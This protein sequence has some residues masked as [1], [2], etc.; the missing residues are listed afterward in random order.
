M[1]KQTTS[2][3]LATYQRRYRKLRATSESVKMTSDLWDTWEKEGMKRPKIDQV[4]SG[5]SERE[6]RFFKELV[7]QCARFAEK[8]EGV[9][10]QCALELYDYN[11]RKLSA[12]DGCIILTD[13]AFER[14][15]FVLSL[16]CL[17]IV[18]ET[19]PKSELKELKHWLRTV[20]Q[21]WFLGLKEFPIPTGG[22]ERFLAGDYETSEMGVFL[23]N[24]MY[25]FCL[26]H[27]IGHHALG[28][29]SSET[30]FML[31]SERITHNIEVDAQSHEEE[32][33]ADDYAIRVYSNLHLIKDGRNPLCFVWWYEFA[34]LLLMDIF[35]L[36][37]EAR[38][39]NGNSHSHP[40]P[41]ERKE[42]LLS[43]GDL[44]RSAPLYLDLREAVST[45]I[46]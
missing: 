17:H 14:M 18:R 7:I 44:Q 32:F 13:E 12:T 40:S 46:V 25:A 16:G 39:G 3:L 36:I 11:F 35:A 20:V 43:F 9:I 28:H 24:A 27:E 34:P 30:L 42:K 19:A 29:T 23:F 5:I 10:E 4:V 38:G 2:E 15:L 21:D 1:K 26:A 22:M 31:P 8:P 41:E 6:K 33:L 45:V 37:D